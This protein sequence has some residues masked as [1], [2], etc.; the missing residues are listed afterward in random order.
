MPG[1]VGSIISNGANVYYRK[2]TMQNEIVFV[3]LTCV[4]ST[5][6]FPSGEGTAAGA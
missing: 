4:Q 1:Y 3:I 5:L 6:A 2:K